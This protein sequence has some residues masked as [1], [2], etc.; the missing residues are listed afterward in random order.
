[1][2]TFA[3]RLAVLL[4]SASAA[5]QLATSLWFQFLVKDAS[6]SYGLTLTNGLLATTP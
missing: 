1:M 3:M 2:P 6:V 5:A 4:L